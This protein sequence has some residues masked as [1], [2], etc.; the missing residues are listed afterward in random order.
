MCAESTVILPCPSATFGSIR[1]GE[2]SGRVWAK[3]AVFRDCSEAVLPQSPGS[4]GLC[5]TLGRSVAAAD[6]DRHAEGVV[7]KLCMDP[8][9]E[10]GD[11]VRDSLHVTYRVKGET[12]FPAKG[13][14]DERFSF[15]LVVA[16]E[17]CWDSD[18]SDRD[19]HL[20]PSLRRMS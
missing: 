3:R 7:G 15:G 19:G 2:L 18:E 11:G 17:F 10:T 20:A 6:P 13:M 5:E 1:C 8:M 4:K 14:D 9:R 12:V 16:D